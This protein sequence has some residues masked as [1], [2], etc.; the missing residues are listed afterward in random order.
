MKII[1]SALF[2]GLIGTVLSGC[3]SSSGG[4]GFVP[5]GDI[6]AVAERSGQNQT[7][8]V[9]GTEGSV[10]PGSTVTVTNLNTGQEQV[11]LGL[12]DGSFDPEFTGSTNDIFNVRVTENGNTVQDENI[13][14]TLLRNAVTRDISN[15][16]TVPANI[17]IRGNSAYIINGT[18]NNIQIF[19]L[20]VSPPQQTG[21]IVVPMGSNPIAMDFLNDSIAYVANNIGQ[22]VAVVNLDTLECE[23]LITGEDDLGNTAPCKE[24]AI[25]SGSPFEEPAGVFI[26]NGK[27]YVS[28]NNLNEF[29]S[30]N[31]NGFITVIDPSTN[32][33]LD[34]IQ[35]TGANTTSMILFDGS[36]FAL[37]NGNVLFDLETFEFTCDFEFPPSIDEIDPELDT[38]IDNIDIGLSEENP[39]VCLPNNLASTVDGFAYTGLGLVGALLKIDLLTGEFINGPDNPIVITDLNGLNNTSDIAI[40][41][42]LLFTTLFNS[43]QMAVVDIKTD[44]INP[45]PYITPFPLGIKADNPNSDLF[46]GAQA[47]AIRPDI[48]GQD[49][50]G[51]DIYYINSIFG[52]ET[53]GSVDSTLETQ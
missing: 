34:T 6:L 20:N 42:N 27:V 35:A 36:I 4:G 9:G 53:L 8:K 12:P 29:F 38:V 15:L 11:T 2:L 39:L 44:Q 3:D 21:T 41:D 14:V 23:T 25:L 26:T 47:L 32:E 24:V 7:I 48:K 33:I 17:I 46:E 18:S 10:P 13:G 43:D 49:F 37:N 30:P 40:K 5:T 19:N 51:A 22:S 31:G 28:N 16:G 50:Q 1:L 45:F 52:V